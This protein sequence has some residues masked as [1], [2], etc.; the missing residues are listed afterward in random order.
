MTSEPMSPPPNIHTTS[1]GDRLNFDRFNV[2]RSSTRCS[3]HFKGQWSSGSV[4][5]FHSTSP[6][7]IPG[8]DK[9]N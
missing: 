2:H 1:T 6:G 9:V 3:E 7:S 5:R 4:S 8:L